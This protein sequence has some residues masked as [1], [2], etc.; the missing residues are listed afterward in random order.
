MLI[1][2]PT[3]CNQNRIC[4]VH[5]VINLFTTEFKYLYNLSTIVESGKG[6]SAAK[7]YIKW[8]ICNGIKH[9]YKHS[10]SQLKAKST[11]QNTHNIVHTQKMLGKNFNMMQT[12][13][14]FQGR[15]EPP[16]PVFR[17]HKVRQVRLGA[18]IENT[19]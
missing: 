17:S 15:T 7:V 4:S 5:L 18:I 1:H 16:D 11:A 8:S 10:S 6:F 19:N 2:Q 12:L 14:V 13:P 3:G 9:C